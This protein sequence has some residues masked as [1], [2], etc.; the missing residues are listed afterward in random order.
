MAYLRDP[1]TLIGKD[2]WGALLTDEERESAI[3]NAQDAGLLCARRVAGLSCEPDSNRGEASISDGASSSMSRR[4]IPCP[5]FRLYELFGLGIRRST[6]LPY[7]AGERVVAHYDAQ[8]PDC[9]CGGGCVTVYPGNLEPSTGPGEVPTS[10]GHVL[11]HELFHH[12]YAGGWLDC[13]GWANA[14]VIVGPFRR[15]VT[16]PAL[17]EI[18]ADSFSEE[19]VRSIGD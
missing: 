7:L 19:L 12:L 15:K 2:V 10:M 17:R 6:E 13:S 1:N 9:R 3:R 11:A 4:G 14:T 5:I 18:A 16:I 8:P